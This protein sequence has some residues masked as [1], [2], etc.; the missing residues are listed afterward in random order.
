MQSRGN[1]IEKWKLYNLLIL[2][3]LITRALGKD[4]EIVKLINGN[5]FVLLQNTERV[6]S[7]MVSSYGGHGPQV[8]RQ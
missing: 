5:T 4:V 6:S 1:I 2:I 7:S 8:Q 3:K